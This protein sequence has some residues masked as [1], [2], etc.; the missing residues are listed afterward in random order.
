M[1]GHTFAPNTKPERAL[2]KESNPPERD[3]KSERK[4]PN[5]EISVMRPLVAGDLYSP[6]ANVARLNTIKG[7]NNV[8]AQ[9]W[10]LN[11]KRSF[12][13]SYVSGVLKIAKEGQPKS[14]VDPDS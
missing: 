10:L 7:P 3:G 5:I 2:K 12:G 13:N 8:Q 6:V 4:S 1:K 9:R 14:E 11:L